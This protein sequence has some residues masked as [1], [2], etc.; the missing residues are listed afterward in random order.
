MHCLSARGILARGC[1]I[2]NGTTRAITT[3]EEYGDARTPELA[4]KTTDAL[5]R[6]TTMTYDVWGN[7]VTVT[8]PVGYG[9]ETARTYSKDAIPSVVETWTRNYVNGAWVRVKRQSREE[10][11]AYGRVLAS[12][13]INGLKT[14]M[15]YSNSGVPTKVT[16]VADGETKTTTNAVDFSTGNVT[17]T[18]DASGQT[19]Y[20]QYDLN[21]QRTGTRS[22]RSTRTRADGTKEDVVSKQT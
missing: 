16:R 8:P 11:D 18:T 17:S 12:Y 3:S 7:M 6:V 4:T 15:E 2:E 19:T 5:G 20:F 22:T 13:D 9:I 14:T 21:H 1:A 10:Y